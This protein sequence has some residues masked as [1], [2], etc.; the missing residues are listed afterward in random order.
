M[1][2]QN[3]VQPTG[4]IIID[5]ARGDFIGNRGI[6][7][8]NDQTLGTARWSHQAWI[9]CTL[10]WQDR[11]RPMMDGRNWTELF[12][13]DEAVAMAA[14]HRPCGYC[15]RVDYVR[16][17]DAWADHAGMPPKAP[18]ID[19]ALHAGRV[20]PRERTQQRHFAPLRELPDGAM[21]LRDET[22]YLVRRDAVLPYQRAQYGPPE[23]RDNNEAATVLTPPPMLNVLRAGF[24]PA[25]HV[26]AG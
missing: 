4:D 23:I 15:R 8:R 5:H 7:H 24:L 25:L 14:G 22:A 13:L 18:Q 1:L 10:S 21:I 17:V 20:L 6:I 26:S 11:K 9:C 2:F 3:R 16:F 19:K 12:F